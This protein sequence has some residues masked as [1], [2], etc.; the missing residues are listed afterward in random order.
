MQKRHIV[1]PFFFNLLHLMSFSQMQFASPEARA[2]HNFL[3]KK[4]RLASGVQLNYVEQGRERSQPVIFLHGITDSWYSYESLLPFL[5]PSIHAYA[6][7]QRGHGDADKPLGSYDPSVFA[8]DLAAFTKELNLGPAIIVGHS[9]GATIAQRFGLDYPQLTKGLVLIGSFASFGDKPDMKEFTDFVNQLTDPVDSTFIYEFQK[10]TLAKAIPA[11]QLQMFVSE[12]RKVPAHVW[13]SVMKGLMAINY[14]DELKK[15]NIP[16][17]LVWG[18]KD[19]F[20]TGQ[21]QETL[22]THIKDSRLITY[23]NTGHAVHW[24]EPLRFATDLLVFINKLL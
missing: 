7:T 11:P 17:L 3:V 22:L 6:I 5:P 1:L 8:A 4:I 21:D 20:V 2:G 12:S 13:K 24:E 15:M 23:K 9:M 16:T 19:A 10:S 14:N 18:D